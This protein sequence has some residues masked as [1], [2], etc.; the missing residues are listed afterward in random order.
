M[1][2]PHENVRPGAGRRIDRRTIVK[3]AA[4]S[5]P[6]I[7]S[8]IAVPAQAASGPVQT[9]CLDAS[10][11]AWSS[12][13]TPVTTPYATT[14]APGTNAGYD[15][16]QFKEGQSYEITTSTT[17]V[18]GGTLPATIA[19]LTFEVMGT[20]WFDWTLVGTPTIVSSRGNVAFGS[21]VDAEPGAAA[22]TRTAKTDLI[23]IAT[24]VSDPYIHPGDTI[25]ITWNLMAHGPSSPIGV[26]GSGYAYTTAT[27]SC[28]G[29]WIPQWYPAQFENGPGTHAGNVYMYVQ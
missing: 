3:G 7:A 19:G 23:P 24:D 4:W 15:L 9:Q 8:A 2:E 20:R 21:A 17:I 25:T 6:V 18:Y 22:P 26:T 13:T 5:V 27:L 29:T 16:Y 11:T 12:S 10:N 28:N 1:T 14:T